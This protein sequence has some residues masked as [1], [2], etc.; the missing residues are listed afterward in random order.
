M[1]IR[2]RAATLRALG[3]ETKERFVARAER[4]A[5]VSPRSF[6]LSTRIQWRSLC[7]SRLCGNDMERVGKPPGFRCAPSGLRRSLSCSPEGAAPSAAEPGIF[8]NAQCPPPSC[9]RRRASRIEVAAPGS[10]P[11]TRGTHEQDP[12]PPDPPNWI[13]AGAG[14]PGLLSAF[15]CVF[16]GGTSER[17]GTRATKSAKDLSGSRLGNPQRP[18]HHQAAGNREGQHQQVQRDVAPTHGPQRIVMRAPHQ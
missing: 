14:M 5:R 13:P 6:P 4:S 7:H 1:R 3:I 2:L 11:E 17:S 12:T 16:C 10:A 18:A 9:P 8:D 15:V